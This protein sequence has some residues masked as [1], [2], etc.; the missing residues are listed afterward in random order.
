MP[1]FQRKEQ[2]PI[3]Q[4][5]IAQP[6]RVLRTQRQR[7][8]VVF[9][10]PH[11]GRLYPPTFAEKS[12]LGP[13]ALRRSE[14]AYVDELFDCA[15]ELGAPMLIARFPRAYLDANRAPMEL[16]PGMFEGVLPLAVDRGSTRVH[17]G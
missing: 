3:L 14:D 11:S 13:T 10:S 2:D 6:V 9:A 16:D 1:V 17:A 8:P 12:R 15:R 5:L 7:V 4:D